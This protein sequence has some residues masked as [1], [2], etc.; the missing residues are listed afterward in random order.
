MVRCKGISRKAIDHFNNKNNIDVREFF[1]QLYNGEKLIC[2][3]CGGG[4]VL[5][6]NIDTRRNIITKKD[7]FLRTLNFPKLPINGKIKN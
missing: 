7:E 6:I 2:D 3:L 1:K 4:E 5:K